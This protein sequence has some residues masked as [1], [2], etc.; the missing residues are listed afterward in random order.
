MVN[1]L[2]DGKTLLVQLGD[3]LEDFQ[4]PPAYQHQSEYAAA[5]YIE[6]MV[7]MYRQ[8]SGQWEKWRRN[9]GYTCYSEFLIAESY[10]YKFNNLGIYSR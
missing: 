6:A 9:I 5:T 2:Y 1:Y 7:H 8:N 3:K 10:H 4:I